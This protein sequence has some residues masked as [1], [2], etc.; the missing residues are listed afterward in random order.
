M[1]DIHRS[2][3]GRAGP[4][5]PLGS[6]KRTDSVLFDRRKVV[7]HA[8]VVSLPVPIVQVLQSPAGELITGMVIPVF[9]LLTGK[10]GAVSPALPFRRITPPTP[11]LLP[12]KRHADGAVHAAGRDEGGLKGLIACHAWG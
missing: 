10:D 3:A 5:F 2:P 6:D 8:H 9:Y 12:E 7:K 11:V 1:M 4:A